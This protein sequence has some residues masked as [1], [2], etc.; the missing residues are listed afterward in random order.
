MVCSW[1]LYNI[2]IISI[3]HK[4]TELLYKHIRCI[5]NYKDTAYNVYE[6]VNL[7]VSDYV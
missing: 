3:I 2:L 6:R 4:F 5:I 1:I 7:L